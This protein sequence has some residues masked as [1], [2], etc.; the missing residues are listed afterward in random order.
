[1]KYKAVLFDLDGTLLDTLEDLA[2]SMNVVLR[3]MSLPEHPTEAY[4]Y[5]IG[6]GIGMLAR[7]VLPVDASDEATIERCVADM[8]DQ[9]TRRWHN[10]T[11]L[12]DGVGEMLDGL[13]RRSLRMAVLSNKPHDFTQLIVA[14][15]LGNWRFEHVWGIGRKVPRKPDPAGALRLAETMQLTPARMFYLGDTATDMKTADAA[16]MFALG[17]IWGFRTAEEL[18]DNGAKVLLENP[19]DLLKWLDGVGN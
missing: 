14:H 4:R 16:G 3:E 12:Y 7:R 10:K 11:R 6:D 5:F 1:M 9:Y 8:R 17:A 15:L 18:N 2:D 13:T 19:T